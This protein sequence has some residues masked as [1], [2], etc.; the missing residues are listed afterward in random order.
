MKISGEKTFITD[1][2]SSF[3]FVEVVL[4]METLQALQSHLKVKGNPTILKDDIS[5]RAYIS[6]FN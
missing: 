3:F 1:Q 2:G 5:S 6:V 4:A